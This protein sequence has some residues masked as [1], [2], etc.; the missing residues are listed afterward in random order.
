MHP[1]GISDVTEAYQ[2]AIKGVTAKS[3]EVLPQ[4][5]VQEKANTFSKLLRADHTT[6]VGKIEDGLQFLSQIVL[7]TSVNAD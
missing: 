7:S 5:S 6:A 2:A 1:S 3:H 4:T